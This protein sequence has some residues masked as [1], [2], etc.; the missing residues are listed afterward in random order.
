MKRSQPA[1]EWALALTKVEEEGECRA[2]RRSDVHL[3]AAHVLG[4]EHDTKPPLVWDQARDGDWEWKAPFLVAPQRIIPLCGPVGDSESCH[5]L[6]HAGRLNVLKL[7]RIDEQLQAV[8]DA[9]GIELARVRLDP[10]DY[11]EHMRQARV[12]QIA[13]A[14]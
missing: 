3:E 2:C 6:Q 11:T 10:D 13:E 5:G 1:R 12:A 14:A 4:R 7:L 9:D 8:A